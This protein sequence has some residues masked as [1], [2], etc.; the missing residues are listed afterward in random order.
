ML[1]YD[2]CQSSIQACL[3]TR[4]F[5]IAHLYKNEKTMDAHIHDCCEIYFSISGG[6]QF[7]I[8]DRIY[9]VNPGDIFFINQFESHYLPQIN[10]QTHERIVLSIHPEYITSKSSTQTDL[11]CCFLCRDTAFGHKITLCS[12]EKEQF[13]YYIH[14]LSDHYAFG[15]DLMEQA[16]FMELLTYLNG[17]FTA[18][19]SQ[20]AGLP[21]KKAAVARTHQKLMDEFFSYVNQHLSEDLSISALADHFYLSGP[22]LC[23]IFKDE[24]GTTISRYITAR[25][26][27]Y[28]KRLLMEGH[29]VTDTCS[30]CGFDN[31]SSFLRSFT[32]I[33]G[34]SPKKYKSCL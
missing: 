31:Y 23:K 26:I 7:L 11:S 17:I 24:T 2:T 32:K 6:R 21:V 20:E 27:A 4:T 28:A 34:I 8:N 22:Y 30:L 19:R 25:R 5:A 15:Q 18:R 10:Q 13:M 29:S 3:D 14:K 1:I 33:V 9:T 16:I 12:D